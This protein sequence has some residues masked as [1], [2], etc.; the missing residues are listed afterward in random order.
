[1]HN[2]TLFARL[3]AA[4]VLAA[5]PLSLLGAMNAELVRE[6][7]LTKY[8]EPT[9]PDMARM[10][11]VPEGNV[12]LAI[13][14]TPDGAPADILVLHATYPWFG[15]AAAAAARE[16]RFEPTNDPARLA[17]RTVRI[18]FRISGVVVYPF[19]KRNL[20]ILRLVLGE[21]E[22]REPVRV[23]SLQALPRALKPLAQPM[24]TYPVALQ[25]KA[26]EGKAAVRFYVDEE[27]RV[28]MPEVIE[29]TTPEFA[30]AALQAVAQWRYEPPQDRGRAIVAADN[31]A[32]QFKANN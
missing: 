31:W 22:M 10:E 13:S 28:R 11:G 21:K 25:A 3:C 19:G 7:R 12:A 5:A 16:W 2:P 14:Q 17:S 4:V 30:D 23:P 18:N 1:M 27:G 29:A 24:P 32:F 15:T 26:I 6:L 9:F 20:D 8:V